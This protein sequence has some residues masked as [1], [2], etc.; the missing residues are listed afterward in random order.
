MFS[1]PDKT[2]P[3]EM[4]RVPHQLFDVSPSIVNAVTFGAGRTLL[5][6]SD[7]S[8]VVDSP[9]CAQLLS[10]PKPPSPFLRLFG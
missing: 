4:E 5:E 8:P 1:R 10:R 6:H 3:K 9:L 7:E 2:I